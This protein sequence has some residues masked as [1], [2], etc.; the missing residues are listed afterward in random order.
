M[1]NREI[2]L[3]YRALSIVKLEILIAQEYFTLTHEMSVRNVCFAV[4]PLTREMSVH[5]SEFIPLC[6]AEVRGH[7]VIVIVGKALCLM[8]F[9]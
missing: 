6:F 2:L 9:L 8:F 5:S 1:Y 3:L 7:S 4:V